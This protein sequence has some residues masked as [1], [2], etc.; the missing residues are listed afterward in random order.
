M[1]RFRARVVP[2]AGSVDPEEVAAVLDRAADAI[3]SLNGSR[4]GEDL[5]SD[6]FERA[7]DREEAEYREARRREHQTGSRTASDPSTVYLAAQVLLIAVWALVLGLG[8][9]SHPW[10]LYP[11]LGW[12]VGVLAHYAAVRDTLRER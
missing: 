1:A 8:G 4:N 3:E 9:T 11:L 2:L 7:A 6:A 10:F 5:M 12:G